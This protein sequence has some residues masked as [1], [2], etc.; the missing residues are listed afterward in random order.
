MED[1]IEEIKNLIT[2]DFSSEGSN[3]AQYT[4]T[5]ILDM[6]RGVIPDEPISE[7]DIYTV[8]KELN[9]RKHLHTV[10]V[11]DKEDKPTEEVDFQLY[12]WLLSP[13]NT[14]N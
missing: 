8:L 2:R 14:P 12:V 3:Y 5:Q 9:F 10:F 6:V 7:H 4:T 11:K 13:K 1:Y